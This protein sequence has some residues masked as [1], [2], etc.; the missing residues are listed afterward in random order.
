MDNRIHSRLITLRAELEKGN[1]R[2][3]ELQS[4]QQQLQETMLRI[5]GAITVLEEF[6]EQERPQSEVAANQADPA[7]P[8]L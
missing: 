8:Q 4:E 6:S 7:L 2:M 5:Q 3:H 1:A